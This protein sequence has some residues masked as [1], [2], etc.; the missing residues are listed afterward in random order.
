MK[1]VIRVIACFM[2]GICVGHTGDEAPWAITATIAG[3]IS[4][5]AINE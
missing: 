1:W 2:L 4:L 3:M 5:A